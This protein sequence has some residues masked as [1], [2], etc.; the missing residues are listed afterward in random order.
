MTDKSL[1]REIFIDLIADLDLEGSEFY[2]FFESIVFNTILKNLDKDKR[3][4]FVQLLDSG[5]TTDILNFL[6]KNIPDLENLLRDR[7][8]T[9]MK[10]IN[11]FSGDS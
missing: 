11:D 10:F 3:S 1:L 8:N 6:K 4:E 7:L 2:E 5:K 9:E